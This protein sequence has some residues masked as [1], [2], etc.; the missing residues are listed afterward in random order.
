VAAPAI[1]LGSPGPVLFRQERVGKN[2]RLFTM[3]KFRSLSVEADPYQSASGIPVAQVTRV[4]R[5]LR[6][7]ALDELPQLLNVLRGD[8]SLVGPRPE[9]PFIV[10]T[11]SEVE[12][13]RLSVRPGITGVWQMSV[14]RHGM[15][16]HENM[17]YD[18]FYI[19]NRSFLLDVVL[20]FETV[21][22]ACSAILMLGRATRGLPISGLEKGTLPTPQNGGA[23]VLVALDQRDPSGL[24]QAWVNVARALIHEPFQVRVLVSDQHVGLLRETFAKVAESGREDHWVQFVPYRSQASVRELTKKA[25]LV[26]TDV[27]H[28]AQMASEAGVKV[29]GLSSVLTPGSIQPT[30]FSSGLRRRVDVR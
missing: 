14:D 15:E 10:E 7:S 18:L 20:L 5:L 29:I 19:S 17:E 23:Y 1:K 22:F 9:M 21:V 11:Y 3:L 8:M 13:R 27:D 4:G 12:R 24:R 28:F 6:G 26:I 16:I 25:R 30:F 2:G